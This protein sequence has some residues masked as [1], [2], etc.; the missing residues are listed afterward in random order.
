M[1]KLSNRAVVIIAFSAMI[2]GLLIVSSDY[3][4]GKKEQAYERVRISLVTEKIDNTPKN[5]DVEPTE[6]EEVLP[7]GYL[8][9][10]TIEKINLAQGFFDK[11]HPD[12]NVDKGITFLDPTDYPDQKNGNVILVAHSGSSSIAYFKHLYQLSIGDVATIR[13]RGKTYTYRINDIYNEIKDGDVSIYRDKNKSTLT[14]V[15]CTKDD[16]TKQTI[17]IAYLEKVE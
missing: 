8:G 3:L 14:M 2:I 11:G 5:I 12:N 13:Y 4:K 1:S 15:T 6:P 17:Y 9:I 16:D 10:L 7:N